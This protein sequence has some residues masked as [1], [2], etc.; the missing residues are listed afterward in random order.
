M[1]IRGKEESEVPG[2]LLSWTHVGKQMRK[3]FVIVYNENMMGVVGG[4]SVLVLSR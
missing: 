4:S 2:S 1:N 3:C